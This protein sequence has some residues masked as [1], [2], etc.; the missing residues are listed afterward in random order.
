MV[1]LTPDASQSV[2]A[3][4]C[5]NPQLNGLNKRMNSH[6]NIF[7]MIVLTLN[8]KINYNTINFFACKQGMQLNSS[9]MYILH[10]N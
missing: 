2:L 4:V 7:V 10:I 6:L 9:Y 8:G 1:I 3:T 5:F